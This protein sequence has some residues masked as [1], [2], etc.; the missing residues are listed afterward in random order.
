[1]R[2]LYA[3]QSW[4]I[5]E[6]WRKLTKADRFDGIY[7]MSRNLLVCNLM[8]LFELILCNTMSGWRVGASECWQI[9]VVSLYCAISSPS[10]VYKAKRYVRMR[11]R[12]VFRQYMNLRGNE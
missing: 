7:C 1:M 4:K 8:I 11:I 5:K 10:F 9:I 6:K 12:T 3:K 2:F